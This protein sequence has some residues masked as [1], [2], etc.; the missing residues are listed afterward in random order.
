VRN[1]LFGLIAL[2]YLASIPWY[3][4]TGETTGTWLGLPGWV[5]VSLACYA[6]AA[7]LNAVAWLL[8]DVPDA[9]EQVGAAT[10]PDGAN[11]GA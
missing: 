4:T 7:V 2:L 9:A 5:A 11:G 3:R 1:A 10:D 6:A 8:T